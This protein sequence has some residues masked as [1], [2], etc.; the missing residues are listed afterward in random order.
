[1]NKAVKNK[2]PITINNQKLPID[3]LFTWEED[4]KAYIHRDKDTGKV[5]ALMSE[6][7]ADGFP[8]EFKKADY[9]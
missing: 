8:D 1:M 9:E 7:T 3:T 5:L 6:E 4:K 2:I